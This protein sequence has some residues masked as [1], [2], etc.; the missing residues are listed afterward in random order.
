MSFTS[1]NMYGSFNLISIELDFR[2]DYRVSQDPN[3][4]MLTTL[5]NNKSYY[6]IPYSII[7]LIE[8][9]NVEFQRGY[10]STGY[11]GS[12]RFYFQY[13]PMYSHY[14]GELIKELVQKVNKINKKKLLLV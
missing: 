3:G 7:E 5:Y 11:N 1:M 10:R 2:Q 9:K 12:S 13:T 14:S 6:G 8:R 4:Y